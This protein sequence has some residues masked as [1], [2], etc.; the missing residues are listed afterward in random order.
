LIADILGN[1]VIMRLA[2]NHVIY[3]WSQYSYADL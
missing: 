3:L 1:Y 2:T